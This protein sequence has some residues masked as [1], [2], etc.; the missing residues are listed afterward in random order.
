MV[1]GLSMNLSVEPNRKIHLIFAV[2]IATL[3]QILR[4]GSISQKSNH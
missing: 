3:I 1:K 4:I 2:A